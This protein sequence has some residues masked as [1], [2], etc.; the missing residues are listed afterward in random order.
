MNQH[1][2]YNRNMNK[3]ESILHWKMTEEEAQAYKLCLQ[4]E[5][6]LAKE[7]PNYR[8]SKIPKKSDPRKSILFKYCFKLL[9]ETKGLIPLDSY[10]F[11]I[12][13]QIRTLRDYNN[14]QVHCLI[15]PSCLC[16]E[17]AWMRWKIWTKK[18]QR[19]WNNSNPNSKKEIKTNSSEI[20]LS[21]RKTKTFFENKLGNN[22]SKENILHIILNK[23]II[24]WASFG[25]ISGYYLFLSPLVRNHFSNIED[26]F[27]VD[28]DFIKNSMTTEVEEEF[29]KI[30]ENE[31]Q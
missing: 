7:L 12:K 26:T 20:L 5:E 8:S 11:Y 17:K 1:S 9:R 30:F 16:G 27:T 22:Y 23:E 2:K 13:A 15:D 14:G 19:A 28:F 6:I 31:F 4:W 18:I 24:K 10:G 25:K 21:L 3:L 29:R